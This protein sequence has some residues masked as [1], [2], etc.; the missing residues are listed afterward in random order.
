MHVFQQKGKAN[1]LYKNTPNSTKNAVPSHTSKNHHFA[2][3]YNS[4]RHH[5]KTS[6]ETVSS[7]Q[8]YK[9]LEGFLDSHQCN[10]YSLGRC[11]SLSGRLAADL[12]ARVCEQHDCVI[13]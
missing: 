1:G 7:L 9:D 8:K 4:L 12:P 11:A 10:D 2:I 6:I 5:S 13:R 3:S